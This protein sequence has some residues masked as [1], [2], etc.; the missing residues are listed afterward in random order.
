MYP[1]KSI[2]EFLLSGV[3]RIAAD[4]QAGALCTMFAGLLPDMK[5]AEIAAAR[6]Q[7][8]TR[9]WS[10]PGIADDV[11][12]LIDGHLALR[13]LLQPNPDDGTEDLSAGSDYDL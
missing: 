12:N 7:V 5:E 2:I 4:E 6:E 10:Q 13:L 3:S 9:F 8:I 1:M 11:L